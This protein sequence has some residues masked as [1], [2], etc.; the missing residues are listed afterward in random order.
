[1]GRR[2]SALLAVDFTVR[3]PFCV[4]LAGRPLPPIAPRGLKNKVYAWQKMIHV[5]G[6]VLCAPFPWHI[7][8][9]VGPNVGW[10][11]TMSSGVNWMRRWKSVCIWI[12][13]KVRSFHLRKQAHYCRFFY[14]VSSH[15]S[16]CV[17]SL[18]LFLGNHFQCDSYDIKVV[19]E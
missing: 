17:N 8:S 4:G 19:C 11:I 15:D 12:I 9:M 13:C 14:P 2:H 1:M 7:G 5:T 16:I 10:S 3:R 6:R 18:S